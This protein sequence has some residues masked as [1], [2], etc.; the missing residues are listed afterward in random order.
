MKVNKLSVKLRDKVPRAVTEEHEHSKELFWLFGV[1]VQ[2]LHEEF[3]ASLRTQL[4][5]ESPKFGQ[6]V[7][8]MCKTFKK[9]PRMSRD[10]VLY[11]SYFQV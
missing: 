1:I 4:T 11:P 7:I 9:K 6:K 10:W 3:E 2:T 5:D 8:K